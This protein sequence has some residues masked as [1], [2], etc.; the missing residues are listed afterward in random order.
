MHQH[1]SQLPLL[2]PDGW[3]SFLDLW[4]DERAG[5][6]GELLREY[7]R[8]AAVHLDA[9]Q[10]ALIQ[11]DAAHLVHAVHTLGSSSANLGARRLVAICRECEPLARDQDFDAVADR[12]PL[13]LSI[14]RATRQTM[15]SQLP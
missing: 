1:L 9:V 14:F 11:G 7:F 6:A 13:L 3:Q 10:T 12:L 8:D 4:D 5:Y 2:D 15:E